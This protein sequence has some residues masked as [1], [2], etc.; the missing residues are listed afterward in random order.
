MWRFVTV[1]I[2][3]AL[4]IV[5]VPQLAQA[6]GPDGSAEVRDVRVASHVGELKNDR[7]EWRS[8]YSLR[9]SERGRPSL[10][11][12]VRPLPEQVEVVETSPADAT[13]VRSVS[14]RPTGLRLPGAASDHD[15]VSLVVRSPYTPESG[16]QP[17]FA[18]PRSAQRVALKGLH[19]RPDDGSGL[20]E[21]PGFIAP[22]NYGDRA[23]DRIE[24]YLGEGPSQP[25]Q[26]VYTRPTEVDG[27]R[28]TGEM[29]S[30][31]AYRT[32]V[33]FLLG[34]SLVVIGLLAGCAYKLLESRAEEERA[35]AILE[36]HGASAEEPWG[37]EFDEL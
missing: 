31:E 1:R 36:E 28:L 8:R 29:T 22:R 4:S 33:V 37:E 12:F 18:G 13:L 9:P 11:E 26:L 15:E 14:G 17:P 21:Y 10:V 24:R 34:G 23:G 20:R 30:D 2:V 7:L 27:A 19:Y 35:E 5:A 6:A 32:R 25:E 3:L 16:L